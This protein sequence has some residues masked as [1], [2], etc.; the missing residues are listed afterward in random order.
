MNKLFA[1]LLASLTLFG[2]SSFGTASDT[3]PTTTVTAPTVVPVPVTTETE[4]PASTHTIMPVDKAIPVVPVTMNNT[5]TLIRVMDAAGC[6]FQGLTVTE[7]VDRKGSSTLDI[8]C[9]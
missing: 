9:K 7:N 3:P 5:A 6:D 2:C 4:K 8:G 1:I